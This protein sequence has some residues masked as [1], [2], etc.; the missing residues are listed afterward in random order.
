MSAEEQPVPPPISELLQRILEA[1]ETP[2]RI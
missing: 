2:I 1:V